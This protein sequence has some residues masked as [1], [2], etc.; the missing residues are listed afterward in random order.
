M[1]KK[2]TYP[3]RGVLRLLLFVVMSLSF[4]SKVMLQALIFGEDLKRAQ[5]ERRLFAIRLSK[6][7]GVRVKLEGNGAFDGPCIY[8]SNHRTYFDPVAASHQ[9][10]VMAIAKQ[11]VRKWPIIGF[12]VNATGTI[13]VNRSDKGS[14]YET[15]EAIEEYLNKGHH[16][17]IYPE[18]T[19]HQEPTTI[20]FRPSVFGIAARLGIPIIPIAIEYG[21]KEDAW[22]GDDTFLPHFLQTFGKPHLQVRLAYGPPM[23]GESQEVLMNEV[24]HWI[25]QKLLEYRGI[26]QL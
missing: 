6:A 21:A 10:D 16:I 23:Y 26:F 22:V 12:G 3:I 7:L 25:D 11:E 17:L 13:F 4:I 1:L 18:G 24:K 9:I 14:R 8:I 2:I 5:K 15:R 20:E 19:T